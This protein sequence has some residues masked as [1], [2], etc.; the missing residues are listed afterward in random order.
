LM[1]F[2]RILLEISCREKDIKDSVNHPGMDYYTR[3]PI[4]KYS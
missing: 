3:N 1:A 4:E 2:R